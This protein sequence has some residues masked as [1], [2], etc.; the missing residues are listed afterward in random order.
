MTS[1][2]GEPFIRLAE[3]TAS[4]S[5]AID[6]GMGQPHAHLPAGGQPEPA[7]ESEH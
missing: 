3:L 7:I 5:L 4:L 6:L 1:E 2:D